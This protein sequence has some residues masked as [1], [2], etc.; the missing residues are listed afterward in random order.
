M[1]AA[2]A[3]EWQRVTGKKPGKGTVYTAARCESNGKAAC[4]LCWSLALW[5]GAAAGTC[6]GRQYVASICS[7]SSLEEE[8]ETSGTQEETWRTGLYGVSEHRTWLQGGAVRLQ[9]R[10]GLARDAG[11]AD[12]ADEAALLQPDEQ[13]C[14]EWVEMAI[15]EEAARER[16]PVGE[17][18]RNL[19]D[20]VA[21]PTLVLK[22]NK[23]TIE[24]TD[25]LY[26]LTTCETTLKTHKRRLS[27]RSLKAS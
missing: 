11:K 5:Q 7:L 3:A 24:C 22:R 21:R 23:I 4:R 13:F 19:L 16:Q 10:D 17:T 12:A 14:Q 2:A 8:A 9:E 18:Q 27:S 25:D 1:I 26:V 6:S 15:W 20:L